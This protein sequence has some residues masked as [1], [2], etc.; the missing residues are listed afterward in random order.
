MLPIILLV[1]AGLF[2]LAAALWFAWPFAARANRRLEAK[3][4]SHG[5]ECF[6][7]VMDR[8]KR[9]AE[10]R[11]VHLANT[12]LE[13]MLVAGGTW[14]IAVVN[15]LP[16]SKTVAVVVAFLVIFHLVVHPFLVFFTT[17]GGKRGWWRVP[18]FLLFGNSSVKWY[19]R[20]TADYSCGF[21]ERCAHFHL[22]PAIATL[23]H[24]WAVAKRQAEQHSRD[25]YQGEE[26]KWGAG[27]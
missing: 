22:F 16:V 21:L 6:R 18:F 23:F 19:S 5:E 1:A 8:D 3:L 9:D 13:M 27:S 7:R 4:K 20:I 15:H 12:I 11:R 25:E 2:V 17:K 24:L 26:E 14:L 10:I